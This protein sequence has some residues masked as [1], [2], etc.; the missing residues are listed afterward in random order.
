[1]GSRTAEKPKKLALFVKVVHIDEK[2]KEA[3][4]K[5]TM[6]VVKNYIGMTNEEV[7]RVQAELSSEGKADI[8]YYYMDIANSKLFSL[9]QQLD[10][11]GLEDVYAMVKRRAHDEQ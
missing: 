8:G 4:I 1:M 5:D 3:L 9:V 7:S 2:C 10:R 11:A 6:T